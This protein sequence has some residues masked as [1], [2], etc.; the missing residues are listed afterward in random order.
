MRPA[1]PRS[2]KAS[3]LAAFSLLAELVEGSGNDPGS[4]A[5]LTRAT[6]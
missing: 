4:T 6:A 1:S 3:E 5:S 2:A